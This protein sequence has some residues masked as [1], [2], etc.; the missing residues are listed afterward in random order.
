M[1]NILE[2]F[3]SKYLNER[4][5]ELKVENAA[6][7]EKNIDEKTLMKISSKKEQIS[8][9]DREKVGKHINEYYCYAELGE[10]IYSISSK[11][12]KIKN[13]SIM[14]AN[15]DFLDEPQ[16]LN[17][18]KNDLNFDKLHKKSKKGKPVFKTNCELY[19]F[20]KSKYCIKNFLVLVNGGKKGFDLFIL[21]TFQDALAKWK[22]IYDVDDEKNITS[23]KLQFTPQRFKNRKGLKNRVVTLNKLEEMK[24]PFIIDGE[25]ISVGQG[26]KLF[27]E[28]VKDFNAKNDLNLLD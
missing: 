6:F 26:T 13:V 14:Y 9:K 5:K 7:V 11:Y 16:N 1:E 21:Q 28:F 8:P 25:Q 3:F 10:L 2:Y 19:Y 20:S 12:K 15:D 18:L 24:N 27:Y 23:F 4:S 22:T 17:D